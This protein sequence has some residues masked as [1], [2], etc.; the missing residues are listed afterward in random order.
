MITGEQVS[1]ILA[2]VAPGYVFLRIIRAFLPQRS[3][4]F[5]ET[6][7]ASVV[8]SLP[9]TFAARWFLS[10]VGFDPGSDNVPVLAMLVAGAAAVMVGAA[11]RQ[12]PIRRV[13]ARLTSLNQTKIWIPLLDEHNYYLQVQVQV[14]TGRVFFGYARQAS[15]DPA[16]DSPDLYLE[17]VETVD[18]SGH[19]TPLE[20]TRGLFIPGSRVRAIQFLKPGPRPLRAT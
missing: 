10:A 3:A 14:D 19:R 7:L 15:N 17:D 11:A 2:Y 12:R 13:V 18:A 5:A 16:A 9:W 4:D 8:L 6:T 20:N 1:A